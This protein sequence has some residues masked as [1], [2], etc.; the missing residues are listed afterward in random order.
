MY[1]KQEK[2]ELTN[3]NIYFQNRKIYCYRCNKFI[4]NPFC[5]L[6]KDKKKHK[7]KYVCKELF[8]VAF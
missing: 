8:I 2:I 3:Y 1:C 5:H 7:K 6:E 4:R